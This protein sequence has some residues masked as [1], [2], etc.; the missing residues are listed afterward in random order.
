MLPPDDAPPGPRLTRREREVLR[1]LAQ[2]RTTQ[3]IADQLYLS[4]RT[5]LTHVAHILGKLGVDSRTAAI[6]A[7]YQRNLL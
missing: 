4:P 3:E 2:G 7:A 1:L 6:A 5:V